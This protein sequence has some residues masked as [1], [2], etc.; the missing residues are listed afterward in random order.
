MKPAHLYRN[1]LVCDFFGWKRKKLF[2]FFIDNFGFPNEVFSG[3][4]GQDQPQ[5]GDENKKATPFSMFYCIRK[6]V[7][8]IY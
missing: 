5:H 3:S 8:H 2:T 7:A 1:T 4:E 6:E